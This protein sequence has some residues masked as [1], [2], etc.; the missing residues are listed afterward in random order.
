VY[1]QRYESVVATS[2]SAEEP[3]AAEWNEGSVLEARGNSERVQANLQWARL[4]EKRAVEGTTPSGGV[5]ILPRGEIGVFPADFRSPT[6]G[7]R[8][9]S[10]RMGDRELVFLVRVQSK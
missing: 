4:D 2:A 8:A 9:E 7:W 5:V 3:I 1:V 10:R 6:A